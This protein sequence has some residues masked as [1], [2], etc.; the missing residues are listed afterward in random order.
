MTIFLSHLDLRIAVHAQIHLEE[1]FVDPI[2]VNQ[3]SPVVLRLQTAR[4]DET[5][6]RKRG[7][8]PFNMALREV[9]RR[10]NVGMAALYE[11]NTEAQLMLRFCR[12]V[13]IPLFEPVGKL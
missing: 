13:N 8:G 11:Q 3:H 9:H 6:G 12:N 2:L 1:V 5:R 4:N 7:H 10:L